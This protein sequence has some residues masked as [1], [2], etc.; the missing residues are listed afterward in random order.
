[1]PPTDAVPLPSEHPL[2]ALLRRRRRVLLCGA[3]GSGKTTLARAAAGRLALEGLSCHCLSADPGQPGFGPP[4]TLSLGHWE[5]DDWRLETLAALA[6]LNAARFRLPLIEA[7]RQLADEA[8]S[9]PLLVDTPGVVR[10]VAGAEL[11]MALARACAAD[12]LVILV[13]TD[14]PPPLAEECRALGLERLYLAPAPEARPPGRQR[15]REWRSAAWDAYLEGSEVRD[16]DLGR[17]AR[18][19]T[20]P[21][22]TAPEAWQGRQLGLLDRR[23]TTLALGEAL[24]LEGQ[25]LRLR[26]PPTPRPIA[27]LMIRDARRRRDGYLGSARPL[28]PAPVAK[29]AR[30][31]VPG[32]A[33]GPRVR[34][35]TVTATLVNGVFG[36]PLLHL[37]LSQ[38]RRSLLFDLGDPGRLP[39][40][41]AHRVSD[42]FISHAHFDHIGGFLW[43]LRSRI[44]DFPPCRIFGPPGLCEHLAG[45][46]RGILWDRVGD[47]APRFEVLELHGD[48]LRRHALVAGAPRPHPLPSRPAPDGLLH[49][50]PA[51]RVRATTLDHGTPV[52][53]FAYEAAARTRVRPARLAALG[54]S[55]GPWLGELKRRMLAGEGEAPILLP[56][57]RT[58]PAARLAETLLLTLPGQRLVY[59]TDLGDTAENRRRLTRLARGARVLFCEAPFLDREAE[60]AART[61]HLTARACGEI[62]ATARV[63]WLAPFHFSRRHAGDPR[64]LLTEVRGR[65][66]RLL[67][68][69]SHL[70]EGPP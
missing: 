2:V 65:F 30:A 14:R 64:P 20:P 40:R 47:K 49:D 44:G 6:S 66:P 1:M 4:G 51:F 33:P 34:L 35:E 23:G 9:G 37:R 62:A 12:A 48:R 8:P 26:A 45:L 22:E 70:Q 31:P 38:Q 17:L 55:P 39:A 69:G 7:A 58:L 46:M 3:P 61:G 53:A 13:A 25:R 10:G 42:V 36:D 29:P 41:L 43:L 11:L 27:G 67:L 63:E 50:E 24:N 52:L 5:A 28:T 56:D 16:L 57:G 15:R 19:G 68:P 18:I 60:Q 54:W 59:A 32:D 21:P